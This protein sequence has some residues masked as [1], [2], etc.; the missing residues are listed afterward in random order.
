M[1]RIKAIV[2]TVCSE[3]LANEFNQH[4]FRNKMQPFMYMRCFDMSK[5]IKDLIKADGTLKVCTSSWYHGN[6]RLKANRSVLYV[7]FILFYCCFQAIVV[8]G[9]WQ[10]YTSS[11]FDS[12]HGGLPMN[13]NWVAVGSPAGFSSFDEADLRRWF[14]ASIQIDPA[15]FQYFEQDKGWT[16]VMVSQVCGMPDFALT[17]RQMQDFIQC[18]P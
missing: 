17:L 15:N 18:L 14:A 11:L 4:V 13:H 1:E 8:Y 12:V 3:E 6:I 7:L 5:R 9:T 16:P 10:G 2:E